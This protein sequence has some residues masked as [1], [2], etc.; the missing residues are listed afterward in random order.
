MS[1]F[2]DR[3][4][5]RYGK[6]T[7]TKHLGSRISESGRS[8]SWWLALCDCGNETEISA[9]NLTDSRG[10]KSCGCGRRRPKGKR[11]PDQVA[12]DRLLYEYRRGAKIRSFSWELSDDSFFFLTTLPCFY[13]GSQPK[14][15]IVR[16]F[17]GGL[18]VYN[19]LDRID[20]T[21]GYTLEN[22]VTC[23]TIC[24]RAKRDM[25]YIDF[26]EWIAALTGYQ[27]KVTR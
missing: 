12:R 14:K 21:L 5:R 17:H 23:C 16:S 25:S 3:T 9:A 15:R 22:V 1:Q 11:T 24:N 6:L 2:V 27:T 26:N 19:G 7:V 8:S 18:I 10:T 20:N 4:G 13:C